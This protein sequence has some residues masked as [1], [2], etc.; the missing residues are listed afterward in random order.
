MT[1][2]LLSS[3]RAAQ[4]TC[5]AQSEDFKASQEQHKGSTT[6][7]CSTIRGLQRS[8]RATQEQH[9]S[10]TAHMCSTIRGVKRV[11]L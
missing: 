1:F 9:K 4:L 10:S 5:V 3:T 2:V 6:H 8:T 7:M 11:M